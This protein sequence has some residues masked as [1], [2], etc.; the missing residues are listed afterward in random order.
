MFSGSES[1]KLFLLGTKFSK[2]KRAIDEVQDEWIECYLSAVRGFS[3]QLINAI[4]KGTEVQGPHGLT[5]KEA[6]P[7][8]RSARRFEVVG[9]PLR[10]IRELYGGLQ[11]TVSKYR[12][13]LWKYR[14]T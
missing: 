9:D 12:G 10:W 8:R 7:A 2:P 3:G 1:L 4:F 6:S 11:A 5:S 14:S 13:V